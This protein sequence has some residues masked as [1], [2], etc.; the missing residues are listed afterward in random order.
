MKNTNYNNLRSYIQQQDVGELFSF[1]NI[2]YIS[3]TSSFDWTYII[4]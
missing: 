2:L 1:F 4:V 3:N